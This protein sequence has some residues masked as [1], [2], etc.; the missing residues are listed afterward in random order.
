MKRTDFIILSKVSSATGIQA[1]Q[2]CFYNCQEPLGGWQVQ[3]RLKK[4]IFQS[5]PSS[6]P[7]Q[8][9]G[10]PAQ[11]KLCLFQFGVN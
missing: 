4:D 1:L 9:E 11:G 6:F 2:L 10:L 8:A 3:K 7:L 5:P